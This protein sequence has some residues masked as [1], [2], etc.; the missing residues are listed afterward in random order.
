MDQEMLY[1]PI[2]GDVMKDPVIVVQ[3]GMTYDRHALCD[4]LRVHPYLDPTTNIRYKHKLTYVD[5]ILVRKLLIQTLGD[6][7]YQRYDDGKFLVRYRK[8]VDEFVYCEF[9]KLVSQGNLEAALC[10]STKYPFDAI[11]VSSTARLHDCISNGA[12]QLWER[13]LELGLED[14]AETGN[15]RARYYLGYMNLRGR[16]LEANHK[17]AHKLIK[18]AAEQGLPKA[19]LLLGCI[20]RG[21]C[22]IPQDMDEAIHWF[23]EAAKQG[24]RK[25]KNYLKELSVNQSATDLRRRSVTNL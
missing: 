14:L 5:N 20:L 9:D 15:A 3:S 17:R 25:A 18:M 7:A 10:L 2:L 22:G 8:H 19:Q 6:D 16:S 21:G 11:S 1:C 24:E 12:N 23:I 4:S 13:A